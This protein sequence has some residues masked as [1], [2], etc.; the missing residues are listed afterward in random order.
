MLAADER[1]QLL[2]ERVLPYLEEVHLSCGVAKQHENFACYEAAFNDLSVH[3]FPP[4]LLASALAN[5]LDLVARMAAVARSA[6]SKE[7]DA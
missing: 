1:R 3:R 4:E 2:L 6:H 7:L 5:D